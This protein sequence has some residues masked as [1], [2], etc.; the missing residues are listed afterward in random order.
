MLLRAGA[1]INQACEG[2]YNC[3]NAST[4]LY[5]AVQ[6][7]HDLNAMECLIRAGA[8]VNKPRGDGATPLC[9]ASWEGHVAQTKMLLT[10]GA[11]QGVNSDELGTPLELA[12]GELQTLLDEGKPDCALAVRYRQVI[13][14]LTGAE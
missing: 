10:A 6:N 2:G 1:D 9:C 3:H 4:P 5:L 11:L 13:S 7:G 12:T 14:M 8:D